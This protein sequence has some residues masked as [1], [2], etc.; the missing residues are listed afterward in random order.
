ME[1]K[2]NYVAFDCGNSS[3][4][5]M[6][7]LYDGSSIDLRKVHQVPNESVNVNGLFYWDILYIFKELQTGLLKAFLKYGPVESVGISTW[8]IDFGLIGKSHQLLGNPLCYRNALGKTVLKD[9]SEAEKHKTFMATGIPDHPMNSVYQL[10]GIKRYL[11]EYY[12]AARIFL[13]IPD[14]LVWLFTGKV[15]GEPT[16]ASTTQMMNMRDGTYSSEV[17]DHYNIDRS[18][19]PPLISHGKIL[20]TLKPE[21][22]GFLKVN[23]CPF[24]STPSHDTASAVVSVPAFQENFLFIS[25]GTWS[26]I[27]T[28][29]TEPIINDDVYMHGFVNE[30]GAFGSITFLKNAT[31]MHILQNIKKEM[32]KT[33]QTYSWDEIV[34]MTDTCKKKVPVF[35]PNDACFFNPGNMPTAICTY[36]TTNLA[37]EEVLT[38]AYLSLACSYRHSIEKIERLTGK[39]YNT[40]HI[41]GGGCKN[42]KLNQITADI[43]GKTVIAG[44]EEATSLGNIGVQ[45]KKDRPDLDLLQIRK[46]LK[47]SIS[48]TSFAPVADK[49]KIDEIQ[50]YYK[51]YKALF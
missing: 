4:R 30:G 12:Q 51:S 21:I 43:T 48:V 32:E 14:L 11:P 44:P 8:G 38:S 17:L 16:I 5:V 39:I 26:L 18:F 33:G 6:S 23:E 31:G 35:N 49:N 41:V 46:L 2:K 13:L 40:I 7:G 42:K 3:I 20:G 29:L 1:I 22:A 15:C 9:L 10:L 34:R 37:I 25:S 24:V 28:E 50:A 45:L 19:M 47:A 27:G 36:T